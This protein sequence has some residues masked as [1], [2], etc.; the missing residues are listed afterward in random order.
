MKHLLRVGQTFICE[1]F[2]DLV[3]RVDTSLLKG[4]PPV[5]NRERLHFNHC[6]S[7]TV[8]WTEERD[9]WTKKHEDKIDL[10]VDDVDSIGTKHFTVI[11]TDMTGGGTG[12]GPHDVYPDGHQVIAE[13]GAGRRVL[14][15]QSGC[16]VGMVTP[17]DIE[18]VSG[19]PDEEPGRVS[20]EVL[21]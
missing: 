21:W 11:H 14:F 1:K 10:T 9:G 8:I 13:D 17:D 19:P 12:H 15:F 16:F 5:V 18:W 3:Y 20:K 2:E 6:S 7:T 4:V